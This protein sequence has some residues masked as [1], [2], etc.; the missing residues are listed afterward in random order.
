[1]EVSIRVNPDLSVILN[2][3]TK[4]TGAG[5]NTAVVLACAES[6]SFLGT[7]PEDIRWVS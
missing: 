2:A 3:P 6:L 7:T 1:M 5:G 4:E